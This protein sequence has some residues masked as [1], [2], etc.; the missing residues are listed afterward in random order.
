MREGR[1]RL[2]QTADESA[3]FAPQTGL[4][5]YAWLFLGGVYTQECVRWLIERNTFDGACCHGMIRGVI[6][7][8]PRMRDVIRKRSINL[9][10]V[11]AC[12]VFAMWFEIRR[13]RLKRRTYALKIEQ[14]QIQ[15]RYLECS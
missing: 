7:K 10:V 9:L 5:F 14:P 4:S 2:Q 3:L 8:L 13:M 15:F 6:I 12:V 11:C 1:T